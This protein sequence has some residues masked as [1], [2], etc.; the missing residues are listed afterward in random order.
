MKAENLKAFYKKYYQPDNAVLIIA[1]KY[2]EKKALAN[3]QQYFGPI[4]KPTRVL[5]PT[6]TV[7]PPQ[8]G[9]R[10]VMLRRTGDIQYIG[11]A[12]HTPSLADKDYAANDALLQILT[13]DP[14][15]LL[16][17]KL[18][19]TKLA[20]KLYGY[21]Q[22]LHDPGFSYFQVEVPKDKSIDSARHILLTTM[23]EVGMMNI[24]DEDLTRAKNTIMK[25]ISDGMNKTTDLA[26]GLTEYIGAGDWRLLFLYLD[27]IEQLRVTDLKA[28]AKKYYKP[29]NRTYGVFIPD[30]TPDRTVVNETPDISKELAGYKGKATVAQKENFEN[31]IDNIKKNIEYGTLPNGGKYALLQKPTKG[32]KITASISLRY[33]DEKTLMYQGEIASI[34]SKML[35]TGTSTKTKKQ[36]ADELDRIKTDINFNK[37]ANGL[38]ISINTDKQNLP[39]ALALLNDMLM[40]LKFDSAEF[41][42]VIVETK[43]GIEANKN[44]PQTLASEKLGKLASNYPKGHPNYAASSDEVLASIATVK[45]EDVKKFYSNFYGANNSLSVFVGELDKKDVT[46]FLQNSFG[47]WNSRTSYSPIEQKYFDVKGTTESINTPDKTNAMLLGVININISEKHADYPAMYM[48]NELLGGG[49]FLSSRIPQRLRENEGMSYGAGSFMNANYNYDVS[50]WGVYAFFNPLYKGRLD[51]AL[52]QEIDKARAA[53]FTKDELQKS[54][55]SWLEQNKTSLGENTFLA[56]QIR[57]YM[58]DGR[59]LDDFTNLENKIKALNLEAVNA[60]LRKYFDPQKLIMIYGGDFDKGKTPTKVF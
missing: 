9:E 31:S 7:E 33:G 59:S 21:S 54:I 50:N 35:K 43:A 34:L 22:T 41:E 26:I 44:D 48:A 40:H 4:P 52:H 1:G 58:R 47:K 60:A 39:A 24:A 42:K 32:D 45:L 19:E 10:N 49:A 13:N 23:D 18:V 16:Y 46:G 56:N 55:T 53:G 30:A 51:S 5:Q 20:S 3:V 11:M 28:A 15:G 6:Y 2:D 17:K 8:D 12:Y 38:V 27:R 36:I 14:S 57:T 37:A 29:S 25:Y